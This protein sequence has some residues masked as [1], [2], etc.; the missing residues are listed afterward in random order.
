MLRER[1][2]KQLKS[3]KHPDDFFIISIIII[4]MIRFLFLLLR[5]YVVNII[6]IIIIESQSRKCDDEGHRRPSVRVLSSVEKSK[7][8]TT[9]MR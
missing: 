5:W 3:T 6:K 7:R 4:D 2:E 9:T 1:F 8:R